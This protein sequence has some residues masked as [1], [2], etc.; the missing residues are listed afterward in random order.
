MIHNDYDPFNPFSNFLF[1]FPNP[2]FVVMM[3]FMIWIKYFQKK[4]TKTN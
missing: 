2:T 1:N 4:N 3:I